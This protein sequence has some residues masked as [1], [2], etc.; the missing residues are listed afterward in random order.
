MSG[1]LGNGLLGAEMRRQ[2]WRRGSVLGSAAAVTLFAGGLLVFSIFSD[3]ETRADVVDAGAGLLTFVL[4]ICAIVL[5]A[6]AGA[7]DTDKGTMRYLVLT[8]RPRWQLALVR[9]PALA[10][11]I[12]AV[13]LPGLALVLLAAALAPGPSPS[14]SDWID[15]FYGVPAAAFLY[16]M[17]SLAIGTFLRSSAVAIAV[18]I[19]LNFASLVIVAVLSEYVSEEVAELTFPVVV[20]VV[21]ARGADAGQFGLGTAA[22]ALA[23]WLVALLGAAVW[24]VQRS[25]Y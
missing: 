4:V 3:D 22:A 9:V 25:E 2:L 1:L 15:L 11:T 8:G 19:V 12:V 13:L 10:V 23:V 5:G 7:Y 18:S 6:I 14:S 16:S 24:Q 20:G 17:L 21:I